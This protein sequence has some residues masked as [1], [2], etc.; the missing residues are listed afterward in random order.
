MDVNRR[1]QVK[2]VKGQPKKSTEWKLAVKHT[3]KSSE[4]SARESA[5]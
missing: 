4:V 1:H 5:E 3:I 2:S